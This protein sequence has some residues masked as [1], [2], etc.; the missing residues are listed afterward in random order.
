MGGMKK[1]SGEKTYLGHRRRLREKFSRVGVQGFHDYEVMELL[2]TFAIPR[3]DVKPTAKAMLKK[4]GG[5]AGALEAPVNELRTLPG[6]GERSAALA[7]LARE[8]AS[9]LIAERAEPL[10]AL[11]APEDVARFVRPRVEQGDGE[12]LYAL[13]LNSK[14]RPIAI[15]PLFDGRPDVVNLPRRLVMKKAIEH[16][17]R[18]IIFVHSLPALSAAEG[19]PARP[20]AMALRS[21][22][23]SVDI[24]VHDYILLAGGEVMSASEKGWFKV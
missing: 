13:Y 10:P 3:R 23:S 15:E 21:L 22:A 20:L 4:F 1:G 5:L 2:L 11:N 19:E 6:L 8:I 17:A 24:L 16:N 14:N 7:G 12:F 18:S 9:V